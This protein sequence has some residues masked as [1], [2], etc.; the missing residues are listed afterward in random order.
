M[1]A[2]IAALA[3]LV[4]FL[5]HQLRVVAGLRATQASPGNTRRSS[6]TATP[7]RRSSGV[8]GSGR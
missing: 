2:V 7:T 5:S 1:T 8:H 4:A 6:A 3:Q